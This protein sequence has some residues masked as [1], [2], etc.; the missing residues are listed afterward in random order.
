MTLAACSILASAQTEVLPAQAHVVIRD[1][2]YTVQ[3]SPNDDLITV[4]RDLVD[5]LDLTP[6]NRDINVRAVAS[7]LRAQVQGEGDAA[8]LQ[9]PALDLP[10]MV[11]NGTVRLVRVQLARR[12]G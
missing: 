3:F 1:T 4:A 12:A 11:G 2:N 10:V 6:Q 9:Q 5:Q 8:L 7:E